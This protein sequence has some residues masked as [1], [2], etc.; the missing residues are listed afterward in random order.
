MYKLRFENLQII[1][2]H[3][4]NLSPIQRHHI[5]Y[6]VHFLFL[7]RAAYTLHRDVYMYSKYYFGFNFRKYDEF[8]NDEIM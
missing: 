7:I 1:E 6:I 4:Q 3:R 2:R 5:E 8:V